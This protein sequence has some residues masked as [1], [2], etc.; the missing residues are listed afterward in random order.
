VRES[1]L[2]I[3]EG[4]AKTTLFAGLAL[5]HI[6]HRRSASVPIAASSRDQAQIMYDQAEGFVSRGNFREFKCLPGYRRIRHDGMHSRIQIFAA[7]ERTGDGPIPT[8]ALIDE[9]HRHRDLRL[10]RTWRGKLEKRGGQLATIST[11][12]EPGSEFELLRERIR[13]MA[14]DVTRDGSFVRAASTRL[15]L[16]EWAVPE[17]GNVEDFRLVKSANPLKAITVTSLR[18]KY[19]TPTMTLA[20]WKRFTCNLPTRDEKAAITEAEWH[21]AETAERIPEGQPIWLGLD[22]GWK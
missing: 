6:K 15:V 18:D 22:V 11:A 10:Y 16:H 17:K 1:W 13:Q 19:A 3:P 9:L 8:L 20:H 12:G 7:D 4:N 21:G 2:I 14:T 5:Y